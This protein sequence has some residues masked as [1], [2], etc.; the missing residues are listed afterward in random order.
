MVEKR[1]L[2]HEFLCSLP[3]CGAE[4]F[5]SQIICAYGAVQII[6]KVLMCKGKQN[7]FND[8]IL[9][10]SADADN[11]RDTFRGQSRSPKIVPFHMFSIVSSC[12]IVTLSSRRILFS[13]IRLQKSRDLEIR[14]VTQGHWEWY[15]SIDCVWF[16]ISVL[17]NAPFLR[18]STS[19]MPWSWKPG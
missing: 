4:E 17:Y 11:P 18:Y 2:R 8:L 10:S 12:A 3:M 14:E 7:F 9:T 1:N 16:P 19:K 15:H 13:D 5:I 6:I